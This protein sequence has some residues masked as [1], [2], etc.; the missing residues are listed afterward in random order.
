MNGKILGFLTAAL[1]AGPMAANAQYVYTYTGEN[2]DSFESLPPGTPGNPYT[3]ADQLTIRL[4][5]SALLPANL[6]GLPSEENF[7]GVGLVS[8][9]VSDGVRSETYPAS[10]IFAGSGPA[11]VPSTF[12]YIW[13][14]S[15]GGITK[16][17]ING[18]SAVGSTGLYQWQ[19]QYTNPSGCTVCGGSDFV[20]IGSVGTGGTAFLASSDMVGRWTD[21]PEIDSASAASG[22]TLLLSVLAM[23]LGARRSVWCP[24]PDSNRDGC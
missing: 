3:T 6:G 5:T 9:T 1:M 20:S 19:S 10:Q 21:A 24:R 4:T 18:V 16:S 14:N 11:P 7:E 22:L 23:A 17:S 8:L 2:F 12:G 15:T 13:T